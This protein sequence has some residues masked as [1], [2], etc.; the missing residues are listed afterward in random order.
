MEIKTLKGTD[1]R[2]LLQAFNDS[3]SDYFIPFK[4][5]EEQF[6]AKLEGNKI[7]L[8]ISVGVFDNEKLL[9]FILH[10]F[11]IID[12]KKVVYNGGT[13]VLPKN[14]GYG[15]TKQMYRYILPVLIEKG[16]NKLIL[17]VITKNIQAIK[18]YEK[19]GFKI[20]RKLGCYQGNVEVTNTNDQIEIKKLKHFNW[21]LMESFWDIHPTWQ[22]STNVINTLLDTTISFGAYID[23]QLVGYTI[24]NIANK[25]IQQIAVHKDF[26]NKRIG[27]TL[28]STLANKYGN[29][30]SIINVDKTS[31]AI[32]NFFNK[33]GLKNTLEQFEMV[34]EL[35]KTTA[36]IT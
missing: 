21:T 18:S 25:Q 17:E 22:N 35:D 9:G 16:I 10:G 1:K 24:Y 8:D 14:R 5:N 36:N 6:T 13:G 27:S 26:R 33:I 11:D 32:H 29:T 2:R 7:D 15:L 4:L 34:L 31:T 12:T 28:I 23:N 3:F 30:L 19:S 20:K